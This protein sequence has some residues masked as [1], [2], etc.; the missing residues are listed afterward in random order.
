MRWLMQQ[1]IAQYIRLLERAESVAPTKFNLMVSMPSWSLAFP[2][3]I[4]NNHS[5]GAD[6]VSNQIGIC[7]D[8]M[9]LAI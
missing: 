6:Q 1:L 5:F 3:Y 2:N 4:L 8:G 7:S 9:G